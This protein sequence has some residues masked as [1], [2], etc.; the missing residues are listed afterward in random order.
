MASTASA[1]EI[2]GISMSTI[3]PWT[4]EITIEDE[5]LAKAFCVIAIIIRPGARKVP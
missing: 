1:G 5:V 3:L 2:G 4:F